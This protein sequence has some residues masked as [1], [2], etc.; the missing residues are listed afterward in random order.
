MKRTRTAAC[1]AS[2]LL[3]VTSCAPKPEDI[4]RID[5]DYLRCINGCTS[6]SI[7]VR[8]DGTYT[9]PDAFHS[10]TGTRGRF[11]PRDTKALRDLPLGALE[12]CAALNLPWT[13]EDHAALFVT[14]LD[15]RA[16]RCQVPASGPVRGA[17][18]EAAVRAYVRL[19]AR[20]YY[21]A[22]LAPPRN[23]PARAVALDP[24][25]G[26]TLT[27]TAG[28]CPGPAYTFR[29]AR[30]GAAT[31]VTPRRCGINSRAHIPFDRIRDALFAANVGHLEP[32]YP[33]RSEDT[34]GA[35]LSL[36]IAS[37]TYV[38]KGPDDMSWGP[39]FRDA[40]ERLDQ[41]VLD[42]NWSPPL[43]GR[44]FDAVPKPC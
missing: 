5:V 2:L 34:A 21:D 22:A 42:T 39:V 36:D 7:D 35:T 25:D 26:G 1:V 43:P 17:S 31:I 12:R 20:E 38:S 9:I 16:L 24:L 23:A 10:N 28:F 6:F 27:R 18:P 40:V 3:L 44:R 11:S 41:I 32:S 8:R 14:L 33:L 37:Q 29:V 19:G 13:S 15:G 4:A 30:D